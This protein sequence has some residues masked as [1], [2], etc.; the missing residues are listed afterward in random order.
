MNKTRVLFGLLLWTVI[1]LGAGCGEQ[2]DEL[3]A[4][5]TFSY[6]YLADVKPLLDKHCVSCHGAALPKG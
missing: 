5:D 3:P 6:T 2:R 4:W 1:G